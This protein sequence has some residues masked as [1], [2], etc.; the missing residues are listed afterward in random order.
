M[1]HA[2][3]A[4]PPGAASGSVRRAALRS[5][6]VGGAP[7]AWAAAQL[8][9]RRLQRRVL[10]RVEHLEAAPVVDHE[11][12]AQVGGDLERVRASRARSRRPRPSRRPSIPI[13]AS[14]SSRRARA[15]SRGRTAA[16][17]TTGS[18]SAGSSTQ[19]S[20][21]KPRARGCGRAARSGARRARSARRGTRSPPAL[22]TS[23]EPKRT[24]SKVTDMV[25]SPRIS[26]CRKFSSDSCTMFA[27][28]R[29]AAV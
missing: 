23:T 14:S 7:S 12:R 16:G 4:S 13:A 15:R 27:P 28:A 19:C 2:P 11:R 8:E 29:R 10:G 18:A 6:G 20:H 17:P 24:L 3:V 22:R 25:A 5:G 21:R 1:K 26:Q 9:Q